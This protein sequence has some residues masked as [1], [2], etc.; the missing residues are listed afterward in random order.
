MIGIRTELVRGTHYLAGDYNRRWVICSCGYKSTALGSWDDS[1]Y[2]RSKDYY[3]LQHKL[4]V[5]AEAAGI[6]FG[7]E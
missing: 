6:E 1:T 4:D 7:E 2:T 5:L 3:I